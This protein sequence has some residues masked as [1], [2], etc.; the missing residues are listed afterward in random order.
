[1][2]N[3]GQILLEARFG[4]R[5]HELNAYVY[6]QLDRG[7][8]ASVLAAAAIAYANL[9]AGLGA[10]T[11]LAAVAGGIALAAHLACDPF[12][13]AAAHREAAGR[14]RG[15]LAREARCEAQRIDA[16]LHRLHGDLPVGFPALYALAQV[17]VLRREGRLA[18]GLAHRLLGLLT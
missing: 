8:R 6:R 13:K 4:V 10:L 2:R 15:L 1:M 14:L 12:G 9:G 16:E 18:P 7:V 5:Y 11:P 17:E 3:R